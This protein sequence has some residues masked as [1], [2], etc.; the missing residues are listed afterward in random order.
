MKRNVSMKPNR[1]RGV[2]RAGAD[3]SK[4][5]WSDERGMHSPE[6]MI[7]MTTVVVVGCMVGMVT[8]RDHIS[9]QFGDVAVALDSLDQSFKFRFV[10][11]NNGDGDFND[12]DEFEF[13]GSFSDDSPTL[14]DLA[15]QAPACLNINLAPAPE[16][17]VP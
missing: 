16:G 12:E 9:Q 8:L 6:A 14:A 15:G 1:A 2:V 4:S 5:L 7:I 11:D 17:S 3:F 13:E 10:H